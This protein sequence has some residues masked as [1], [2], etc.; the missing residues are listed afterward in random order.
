MGDDYQICASVSDSD[1][2]VVHLFRTMND[3]C[4]MDGEEHAGQS[5][6]AAGGDSRCSG[7]NRGGAMGYVYGR[8]LSVD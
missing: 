2:M 7:P 5:C 8:L 6:E 1:A 4:G 3:E